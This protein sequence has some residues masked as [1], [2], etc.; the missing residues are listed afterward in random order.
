M[1]IVMK[2]GGTSVSDGLKFLR[3]AE[4]V[5]KAAEKDKVVVVVS[6]MAGVTDMLLDAAGSACR[7]DE[8]KI[9]AFVNRIR[10]KHRRAAKLAVKKN[11]KKILSAVEKRSEELKETLLRIKVVGLTELW[12][13]RTA[14]FGEKMSA[15]ILSGAISSDIQSDWY[16]G[17]NGLIVVDGNFISP[18]PDMEITEKEVRKKLSPRLKKGIVPVVTGYMGC[19]HDGHTTTLGRGSSDHIAT[20]LAY[21]LDAQEVQ[22]WT[23]VDGLLTADPKLVPKSSLIERISF[24]EAGELA[25]FGAKVLHPKTM[26]PAMKKNI[27]IRVMNTYRPSGPGTIIVNEKER[28]PGIVKAITVKKDIT[29]INIVSTKMLEAHGF[30]SA[31]FDI[32]NRRGISVDMISTTEV[33][34]SLTIDSGQ[35]AK[36]KYV[37]KNLGKIAEAC[38]M[39]DRALVCVVGE[40]MKT[41]PGTAGRVFSCL[42]RNGIN[43]ESISQGASEI[44]ISFIVKDS[45]A[46]RAVRVLHDE[47]FGGGAG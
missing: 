7:Y 18:E 31:V 26:V 35:D 38:V 15:A 25:Y 12:K 11:T 34:I 45:E 29:M 43:V 39:K 16:H 40:G 28:H 8:K 30:M 22:I 23:D 33:S 32:F 9:E 41:V 3:A 6:A 14:A 13:D 27:P 17:D 2:F 47:F 19:T 46:D 20:I 42:G 5:K 24:A 10:K 36:L 37:L 44:N 1:T 4:L 21:C